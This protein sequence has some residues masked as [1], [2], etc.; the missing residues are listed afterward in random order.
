MILI[1]GWLLTTT[2]DPTGKKHKHTGK[3]DSIQY[4]ALMHKQEW[5]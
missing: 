3:E 5:W 2:P 1:S 4:M